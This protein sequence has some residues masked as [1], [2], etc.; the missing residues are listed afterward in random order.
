MAFDYQQFRQQFREAAKAR[1]IDPVEGS[2]IGN[3]YVVAN[4][5][6]EGRKRRAKQAADKNWWKDPD[7]F[8]DGDEQR[9][10]TGRPTERKAMSRLR[11]EARTWIPSIEPEMTFAEIVN[12]YGVAAL[13]EV[14][15]EARTP[16]QTAQRQR[17]L[18]RPLKVLHKE[19]HQTEPTQ[20]ILAAV[21]D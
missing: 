7:K 19:T 4:A 13:Q 2:P 6:A 12:I 21:G 8:E 16:E 10:H 1:G 20:V 5:K 11:Y 15:R 9:L 17:R 18:G 3:A 14:V